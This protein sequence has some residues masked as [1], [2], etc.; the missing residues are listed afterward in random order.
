MS[1]FLTLSR[2]NMILTGIEI[3]VRLGILYMIVP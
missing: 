1:G 3:D 2:T